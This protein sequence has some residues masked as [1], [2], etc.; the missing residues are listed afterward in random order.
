MARIIH[1]SDWHIG[2]TLPGTGKERT[3]EHAVFL[4][5]LEAVIREEKID[6]LLIAG[7]IFDHPNPAAEAEKLVFD[8]FRKMAEQK[9]HVVFI[10]GNHDSGARI[11]GKA[12]LLELVHIHAFGKPNRDAGVEIRTRK[13]ESLIVAALPFAGELRLLNWEETICQDQGQQKSLFAERM[14][15]LLSIL[16]KTHFKPH[17][18]NIT[19]AHLT[20]DGALLSGSERNLRMSD[21]WTL[22]ASM[23]PGDAGYIA[24]GH[25]HKAQQILNAPVLTAYSGSPLRIDFGEEKESK[26]VYVLEAF[27][28]QPVKLD[29][30]ELQRV[31]PVQ[32]IRST[33]KEFELQAKRFKDFQGHIKVVISLDEDEKRAGI[34]EEVRRLLPQ[35]SMI[36]VDSPKSQ[37]SKIADLSHLAQNPIEAYKLYLESQNRTLTPDLTEKLQALMEEAAHA[38][39]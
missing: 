13:D 25:L 10:A 22:P 2:V 30:R 24:L 18:V 11:E 39:P 36:Q 4:E 15:N 26:G 19:M 7:D 21:T 33:L 35:T 37:R 8:F 28:N 31:K 27:S 32:T 29:F 3:D 9:V 1:T 12:R 23:L 14:K 17:A 5:E 34:A 20:I 38:S 16:A 6:A